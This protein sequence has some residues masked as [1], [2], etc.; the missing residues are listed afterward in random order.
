MAYEHK[1]NRFS[2]LKNGRRR[3]D[4]DP[5]Y[6]GDGLIDLSELGLGSGKAEVWVSLWKGETASGEVR[7]SGSIRAKTPKEFTP[8]DNSN[9][10]DSELNDD[11]PF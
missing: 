8:S 1:P 3:G 6:T 2:L 11:I 7:L 9:T 4:T 5:V 10:N